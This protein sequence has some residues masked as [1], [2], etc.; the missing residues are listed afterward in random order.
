MSL[1]IIIIDERVYMSSKLNFLTINL[2]LHM[3]HDIGK[4]ITLYYIYLY[5]YT[6]F[7]FLRMWSIFIYLSSRSNKRENI[8]SQ[9]KKHINCRGTNNKKRLSRK[10]EERFSSIL[11][12]QKVQLCWVTIEK[13]R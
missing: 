11:W 2:H 12:E 9:I 13:A 6:Y 1:Q 7:L 4:Y 8:T 5:I 10:K 3:K